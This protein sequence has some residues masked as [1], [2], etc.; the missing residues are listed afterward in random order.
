MAIDLLRELAELQVLKSQYF[1]FLDTKEWASWR[2]LFTDDMLYMYDE[3]VPSRGA[4]KAVTRGGDDFVERASGLLETRVTVHHG[5]TPELAI[6]DENTASGIWAMFDY[7]EDPDK[8][9]AFQGY[10]HYHERYQK[11]HGQWR[12][13]EMRLTRLRI[14]RLPATCARRE[15]TEPWRRAR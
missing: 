1:R 11:E 10:G 13:A 5:H 9:W 12:V 2:S 6:V 15:P 4:G 14:D 7:V 3:S 8:G